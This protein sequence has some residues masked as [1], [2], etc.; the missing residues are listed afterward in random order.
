MNDLSTRLATSL[1]S[2]LLWPRLISD[3]QHTRLPCTSTTAG[4][5]QRS[6]ESRCGPEHSQRSWDQQLHCCKN[7]YSTL[8]LG[9]GGTDGVEGRGGEEMRGGGGEER[10]GREE[11][12]KVDS[13]RTSCFSFFIP[14]PRGNI[15]CFGA[16]VLGQLCV[17]A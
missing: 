6:R 4:T 7:K 14:S 17:C 5:K 3:R 15:M 2:G 13:E 1:S 10:K 12:G 8:L 16:F 9:T 11:R